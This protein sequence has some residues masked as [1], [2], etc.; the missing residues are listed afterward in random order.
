MYLDILE[1]PKVQSLPSVIIQNEMKRSY[2][3]PIVDNISVTGD[4]MIKISQPVWVTDVKLA[5]KRL[6]LEFKG[7]NSR[8]LEEK[9]I[10]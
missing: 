3:I 4:V 9:D 1:D 8:V 5:I 6:R 7:Q 10:A 2:V